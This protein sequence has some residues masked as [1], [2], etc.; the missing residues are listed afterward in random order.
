V[1][2]QGPGDSAI[3]ERPGVVAGVFKAGV[4]VVPHPGLTGR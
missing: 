4:P 2:D 3:F 1:L